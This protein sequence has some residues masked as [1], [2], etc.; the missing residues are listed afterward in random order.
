MSFLHTTIVRVGHARKTIGEHMEQKNIG[1]FCF[2][3]KNTI[4]VNV[5]RD[6]IWIRLKVQSEIP[7]TT[8]RTPDDVRGS[9]ARQLLAR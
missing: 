9:P 7:C 5:R 6:Q 4:A 3:P 8:S 1:F 2:V